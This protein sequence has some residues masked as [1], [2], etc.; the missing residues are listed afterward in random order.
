MAF[1]MGSVL[2]LS[3]G[4]WI[5]S[6]AWL[7]VDG[8]ARWIGWVGIATGITGLAWFAWFTESAV[9]L[10]FL[11]PNVLLALVWF[12]AVSITLVRAPSAVEAVAG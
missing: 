10:A 6:V 9:V 3:W 5:L 7:R 4:P 2:S 8:L 1:T 12:A 11:V